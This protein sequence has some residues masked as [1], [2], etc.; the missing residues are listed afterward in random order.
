MAMTLMPLVL[1]GF[2]FFSLLRCFFL[3]LLFPP[4][5]AILETVAAIGADKHTIV[6]ILLHT[7]SVVET[8][9][10][11]KRGGAGFPLFTEMWRGPLGQKDLPVYILLLVLLLY[12]EVEYKIEI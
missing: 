12:A 1:H 6:S 9:R 10:S 8:T 2:F 3:C 5:V 7:A 11:T 4:F